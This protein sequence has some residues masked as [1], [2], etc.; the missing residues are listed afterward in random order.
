MKNNTLDIYNLNAS[1]Y[2]SRYEQSTPQPLIKNLQTFFTGSEKLL[3]IGCGSGNTANK[4]AKSGFNVLATD[5][6]KYMIM[7]AKSYHNSSGLEFKECILPSVSEGKFDGVY[8]IATL[9]HL[10]YRDVKESIDNISNIL[11]S[12]GKFYLSV[13]LDRGDV[14]SSGFDEDGRFFLVLVKDMWKLFLHDSGFEIQEIIYNSDDS[15]GRTNIT[16]CD[17]MCVKK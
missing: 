12:N 15:L 4:M 16:W 6:S 8:S 11:N 14:N 5:G 1:K 3:E 9:M 10:D 2:V 7:E 17:F 13:S